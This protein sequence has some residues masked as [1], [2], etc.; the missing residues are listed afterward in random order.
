VN[1]QVQIAKATLANMGQVVDLAL[2]LWPNHSRTDLQAELTDLLQSSST[3]F[4]LVTKDA[5]PVAFAQCSIRT[6]YVEGTDSSPVGYLEGIFVLPAYRRQGIARSLIQACES[7][8]RERG[9]IQLA[10][11][12]ELDNAESLAFHLRSGFTEVNRLICFVKN[13]R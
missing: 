10:S 3:V 9:C 4:F 6:D 8:S 12:C 11:D 2:L 5:Q 7:W 13:I 1:A